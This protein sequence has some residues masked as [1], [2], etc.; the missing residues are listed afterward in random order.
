MAGTHL[1]R[2]TSRK[3]GVPWRFSRWAV[4]LAVFLC[5][6]PLAHSRSLG[7]FHRAK[8]ISATEFSRLVQEF[9]EEGGQFP[10]D[11]FTSNERAY[12]HI[13]GKLHQLGVSGGAY[14]GVGPEQNFSYIAKVRPRIAF[15]VDI[16]R[17]AVIQHLMYKAVFHLAENRAQF[18]SLLCG[19]PISQTRPASGESLEDLLDRLSKAPA[20][21][22]A[23]VADLSSI[24]KTIEEGFR[25]PLLPEDAKTLEYIYNSFW[26]DNLDIG[27]RFGSGVKI[28]GSW[29]F[30]KLR[31]LILETDLHGKRGNFLAREEDYQFVRK[32]Q[33]RNLVIPVVGDFAG[34]KALRAVGDYLRENGYTVSAFY[35]SNVEEY[36]YYNRVYGAFAENVGNLP[37]SDRS[38]FIRAVR[39]RWTPH[40][41]WAPNDRIEPFLQKIS[42]F[43]SDFREGLIPT[44]RDLVTTHYL[45]G[46]D[47]QT[48]ESPLWQ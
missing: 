44:Y 39:A 47:S 1:S 13:V 5:G 38:V 31:D 25:Y 41:F 21:R 19:R 42:V 6:Q 16:R 4:A 17:Q 8:S 28:A 43:L 35:T 24:R 32:L 33:E 22:E 20:P 23:F 45:P 48:G 9:S 26:E 37:I 15:I 12:L 2:M 40:S 18:L 36:L 29:G 10:T 27:F 30:P 7:R 3:A 11:N 46:D 34:G 14:I